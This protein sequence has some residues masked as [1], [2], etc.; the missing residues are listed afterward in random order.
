[1]DDDRLVGAL[2][3]AHA[4]TLEYSMLSDAPETSWQSVV[5]PALQ[6]PPVSHFLATVGYLGLIHANFCQV[7]QL[8]TLIKGL[9]LKPDPQPEA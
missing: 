4:L 9:N 3:R 6:V 2:E 8:Q 5:V 1:V 7:L